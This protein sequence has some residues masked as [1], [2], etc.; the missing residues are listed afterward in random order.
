MEEKETNETVIAMRNYIKLGLPV[1]PC[2]DKKPLIKDWQKRQKTTNEEIE[3][4]QETIPNINVGLPMGGGSGIIGIDID[5]KEAVVR[6]QELSKGN[7]PDTWKFETP[8]GGQRYLYK[9]PEGVITKKYVE[10]L[11][12]EHS[13][14]A[15]LGEGQQTILPPSVHPNGGIYKWYKGNSPEESKLEDA[16]KWMLDL[17]TDNI[18]KKV[19]EVKE[20]KHKVDKRK[21][22]ESSKVFERLANRCSVFKNSLEIQRTKGISEDDWFKWCKL[23]ISAGYGDA[24][25]DFSILSTKHNERSEER[26]LNLINE[27]PNGGPMVRCSTFGCDYCDIEECFCNINE[28]EEG[29]ITNSPGSI[30][31]KMNSVLPPKNRVYKPYLDALENIK[32]YDIDEHGNLCSYD[33]KGKPYSIANFVARPELEIIRDDGSSEQ[34]IFRIVGVQNGIPLKAVDISASDFITMNWVINSWGIKASIRAGIAKKE[35]CRDAIQN[36]SA[37]TEKLIIYTHMGWRKLENNKWIFLHSHGCI[38]ADNIK[39]E[40]EKSLERYSLP[41][42][43]ENLYTAVKASKELLDIAPKEI[44][45]PLLAHCYLSPLTEAFKRAGIEPNFLIW[46]YGGTGTRKTTTA[47]LFLNHF[48]IFNSTPPASFKDT[49]N[50]IERKAFA[51]KD[52]LLLIDDYHPESVKN[53]ANKMSYIAQR[54]LRMFGDRIGRARLKSSIEFQKD[55]PPRGQAI[56]TGEDVPVGQSS[57]ARF[58]GVEI[59]T[60]DVDLSKLS[61]SQKNTKLFGEAMRGYIEWLVPQME[62]LPNVLEKEFSEKRRQFQKLSSHGRIGEAAAWLIISYKIMLKY[63]NFARVCNQEECE[64]LFNEAENILKELIFKQNVLVNEE[65]PTEIF[66]RILKEIIVS[67]KVRIEELKS[68]NPQDSLFSSGEIIGWKDERFYYLRPLII[69]NLVNKFLAARGQKFPIL[70]RTLWKQLDESKLIHIEKGSDGKIQRCP[71][72]AVPQI[73][74]EQGTQRLR[75]L[76]LNITALDLE[77][78]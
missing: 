71:K 43:I 21:L 49:A 68:K 25:M 76:H 70:E 23:L 37:N 65:T 48:G 42:K 41:E 7:L 69:Y 53:E 15:L 55:F 57:V 66:L 3:K 46:L 16:P 34:R 30:I 64:I 75:L 20:F 56:V 18:T 54:V 28:N 73:S 59:L 47:L 1:I 39:V 4:W 14:L 10:T 35:Q 26:I 52:A 13:E 58:L 36:M 33:T 2:K 61:D 8:G 62:E 12:G 6:L 72:K 9:V 11:K 51:T 17:M 45:V 22:I 5:G 77:E 74:G 50:A 38:G 29:E 31:K 24:A 63:F 32:E 27:T 60:E 78:K 44:T 40:L 19:T 67:G